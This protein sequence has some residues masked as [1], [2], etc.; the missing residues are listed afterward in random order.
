MKTTLIW[1][2]LFFVINSSHNIVGVVVV[3]KC[4]VRCCIWFLWTEFD[5]LESKLSTENNYLIIELNVPAIRAGQQKSHFLAFTC[6]NIHTQTQTN[7]MGKVE[8]ATDAAFPFRFRTCFEHKTPYGAHQNSIIVSRRN[9]V[10]HGA[11]CAMQW[12]VV[13]EAVPRQWNRASTNIHMYTNT[14]LTLSVAPRNK[15]YKTCHS[16]EMRCYSCR[17]KSWAKHNTNAYT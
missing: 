8:C 17:S 4:N 9:G 11:C 5:G 14:A 2:F 3:S 7:T 6:R 12:C 10:V 1:A 15:A 16:Y 13:Q